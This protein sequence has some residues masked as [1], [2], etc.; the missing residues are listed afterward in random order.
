[1]LHSSANACIRPRVHSASVTVHPPPQRVL[2]P[3]CGRSRWRGPAGTHTSMSATPPV[4]LQSPTMQ[5]SSSSAS[6][7]IT[8]TR[9][10]SRGFPPNDLDDDDGGKNGQG[11]SAPEPI[12][13]TKVKRK[14]R[15]RCLQFRQNPWINSFYFHL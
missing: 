12:Q 13:V 3:R 14:A 6:R 2:N 8:N 10:L 11:V 5:S 9:P 15:A 4:S 1:M 7:F